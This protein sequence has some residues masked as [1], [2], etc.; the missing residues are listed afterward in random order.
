[1]TRLQRCIVLATLLAAFAVLAVPRWDMVSPAGARYDAGRNAIWSRPAPEAIPN[2]A[3]YYPTVDYSQILHEL[4]VALVAGA[5]AYLAASL[6]R[7]AKSMTDA[8][9]NAD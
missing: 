7:P 8:R 5:A 6:L 3:I 4:V 9:A 2:L 1:M